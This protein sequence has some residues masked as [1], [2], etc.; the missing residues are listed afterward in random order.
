VLVL[1][2]DGAPDPGTAT[3]ALGAAQAVRDEGVTLHTVAVGDDA[4]RSFLR[5]AAGEP[6][7]AHFVADG[8]ELLRLYQR[9]AA[10]LLPCVPSWVR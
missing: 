5:Q 9:L 1:L 7:R 4:D 2:S 8:A 6:S 10:T 3:D